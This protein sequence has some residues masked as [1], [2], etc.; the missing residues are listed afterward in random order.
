MVDISNEFASQEERATTTK[1]ERALLPEGWY[2]AQV[3]ETKVLLPR[4]GTGKAKRLGISIEI[5]AD[6]EG[7]TAGCARRRVFHNLNYWHAD[8]DVRMR[9]RKDL[10]LLAGVCG[11]PLVPDDTDELIGKPFEAKIKIK[12]ADLQYP[13]DNVVADLRALKAVAST[14]F[15]L[16]TTPAA[17]NAEISAWAAFLPPHAQAWTPPPA[18]LPAAVVAPFVP[19]AAPARAPVATT[20]YEVAFS[21]PEAPAT[22]APASEPSN[23]IA[24]E[25]A[26]LKAKSKKPWG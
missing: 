23:T 14:P 22:P 4:E 17:P 24:G 1:S 2:A 19:A 26:A 18:T 20:G 7:N 9:A 10:Q 11:F 21:L 15:V 13:E 12:K 6:H 3:I 25:L 5:I 16:P 8:H